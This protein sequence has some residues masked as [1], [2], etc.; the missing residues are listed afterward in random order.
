MTCRL[1]QQLQLRRQQETSP[2]RRQEQSHHRGVQPSLLRHRAPDSKGGVCRK[3]RVGCRMRRPLT[4]GCATHAA[5]NTPAPTVNRNHK[6]ACRSTN[7]SLCNDEPNMRYS[8]SG[9]EHNWL[10]PHS[11]NETLSNKGMG[12]GSA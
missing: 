2:A 1:Q 3:E 4:P 10:W 12:P 5:T 11:Q 8:S 6:G 9:L 7:D